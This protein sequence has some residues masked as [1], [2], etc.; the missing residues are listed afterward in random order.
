MKLG[1]RNCDLF[2]EYHQGIKLLGFG[3]RQQIQNYLAQ[4]GPGAR[5]LACGFKKLA[6]AEAEPCPECGSARWY[7]NHYYNKCLLDQLQELLNI[8]PE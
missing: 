5:C 3:S 6:G 7:E 8:L 4:V 1:T 2:L